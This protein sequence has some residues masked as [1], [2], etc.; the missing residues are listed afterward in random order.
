MRI[1]VPDLISNSYFP[2]VAA[3]ELGFFRAEGL[4]ADLELMFPVT[5]TM[6]ALRDGDLDFV[7]GGAP[8]PRWGGE[9]ALP[10]QSAWGSRSFYLRDLATDRF[11]VGRFRFGE[12]GVLTSCSMRA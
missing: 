6:A 2:A 5:Q 11:L 10:P 7:A 3:V 9:P 1:A 4:E 8:A 12:G